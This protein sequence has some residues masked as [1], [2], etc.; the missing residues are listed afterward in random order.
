MKTIV[1]LLFLVF[2]FML[3]Q[4]QETT[5]MMTYN[6]KLDYPKEGKNS[7]DNRKDLVVGQINFYDPHVFGVQEALPNQMQYL[8]SVLV[9]FK[10]VGV[11]RDDGKNSGEY[12]AIFY[13]QNIFEIVENGTFW[14]SETPDK[15][16]M[17]WDAV[18]NR[19]CTYALF[20]NVKTQQRFWVF[21]THFDHVG[22]I[23]RMESPKLI[24]KKV[25]AINIQKLPVVLMGDFN[26][27]P[28]TENIK[29]L[30]TYFNDSKSISKDKP[31][32]PIGTYNGFH[33]DRPVSRRIDYILTSKDNVQVNKYAV[34]SN[35]KNGRYPSD[36]FPVYAEITILSD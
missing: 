22:K 20:E 7:W 33:F 29:Q 19:I 36:H 35:P 23:A 5:R 10:Y 30:Y 32:G 24:L 8:D 26:L 12:S 25:K 28:E 17:G 11:G 9:D 27:E 13:N 1:A 6:I 2:C 34:L 16:S 14:L 31:F 3:V 15:V 4:G 21:N 18:C